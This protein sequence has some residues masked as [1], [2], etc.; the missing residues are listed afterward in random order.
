MTGG[1]IA[2][3]GQA[4][5][6]LQAASELAAILGDGD[7]PLLAWAVVPTG[8]LLEAKLIGSAPAGQARGALAAW[9]EAL[10]LGDFREWPG[11]GGTTRLHAKERHGEVLVRMLA[12]VFEEER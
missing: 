8:P 3:V 4:R 1:W 2:R 11:G 7:L 10:S 5:W 9:R 6:P 12:S